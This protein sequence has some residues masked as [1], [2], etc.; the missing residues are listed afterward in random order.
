ME[1]KI[2]IKLGPIEV[3]YE[4]SESFLKQELPALIKTVTEL[5]KSA[6]VTLANLE[7]DHDKGKPDS[8]KLQLST[9]SIATKISCS[10]GPDLVLAAAAHLTLVKKIE[11][12]SRKQ[13]LDDMKTASGF[14]KSTYRDNLSAY[15]KT[16]LKDKL[17]ERS[18]GQYSLSAQ[19]KRDVESKLVK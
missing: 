10:S 4:G 13:L 12:F 2:R 14:Y 18:T 6:G 7:T 15:I 1:S 11:V 16:L 8:G 17:N 9:T 3:E 5:S 19:A